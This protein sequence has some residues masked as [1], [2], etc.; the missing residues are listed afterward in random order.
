MY[1][2]NLTLWDVFDCIWHL[3][4]L[5][6]HLPKEWHWSTRQDMK[7]CESKSINSGLLSGNYNQRVNNLPLKWTLLLR[8]L[9]TIILKMIKREKSTNAATAIMPLF[10]WVIW[11]SIWKLTWEKKRTNVN[12]VIMHS[13]MLGTR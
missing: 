3:L 6:R 10:G 5:V 1:T 9:P 11:E 4:I 7:N 12:N 2:D 13:L 8:K